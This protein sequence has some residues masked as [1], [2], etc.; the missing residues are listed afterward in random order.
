MTALVTCSP[1]QTSLLATER[2]SVTK[3]WQFFES[4]VHTVALELDGGTKQS[5]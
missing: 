5:R 1:P 3:W 2:C 4:S